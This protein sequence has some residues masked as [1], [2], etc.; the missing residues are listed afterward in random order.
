MNEIKIVN[1]DLSG[2]L[3]G[4]E[5]KILDLCYNGIDLNSYLD[6][7]W[8]VCDG[9]GGTV[10]LADRFIISFSNIVVYIQKV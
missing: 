10:D 6:E 2:L 8:K 1:I 5:P 4:K 3:S 7:G 9:R